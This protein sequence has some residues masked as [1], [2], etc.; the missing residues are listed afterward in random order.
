MGIGTQDKQR[1]G[2]KPGCVSNPLKAI[3]LN[4]RGP[5]VLG[6]VDIVCSVALLDSRQDQV[7]ISSIQVLVV[8][9]YIDDGFVI[10]S[11]KMGDVGA[12]KVSAGD[13]H[14]VVVRERIA[15]ELD[16]P[17]SVRFEV[18]SKVELSHQ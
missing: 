4:A 3:H 8:E 12:K 11:L 14:K 10:A 5:T 7:R 13:H 1:N 6:R 15:R 16:V 17:A 2:A 9:G 18:E